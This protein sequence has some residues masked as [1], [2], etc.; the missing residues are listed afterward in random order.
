LNDAT[1]F[2]SG[3]AA[4]PRLTDALRRS[5][6]GD[7]SALHDLYRATS[8]K[9]FGICLR[10]LKDGGEA[11]EALREVYLAVW[12]RAHFF[13]P[14]QASPI[15]WLVAIA[16]HRAID[17]LRSGTR[18]RASAPVEAA[19]D[20]VDPAPSAAAAVEIADERRRLEGCLAELEQ[21]QA[22]AIRTAFLEGCTYDELAIRLALPP[23]TVKTWIR[24]GLS[25]LRT[26]LER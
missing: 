25:N 17:R 11:E 19:L 7:R 15:T 14:G 24:R 6:E 13:D 12:Q 21:Q 23:G 5:A 16:R 4:R 3:E 26:C 9:L 2:S 8:A 10:I 20:L 22:F 18:L 1:T